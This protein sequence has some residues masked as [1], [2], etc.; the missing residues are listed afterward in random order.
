MKRL[1][2]VS[3]VSI[4][5]LYNAVIPVNAESDFEIYLNDFYQKQEKASQILKGIEREL[6]NGS[7]DKICLKQREAA[8]YGI[9]ATESLIRAFAIN[10]SKTQ[11]ESLI[12]GLDKWKKLRDNC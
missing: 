12:A 8:D 9:Q 1:I 3:L 7:R 11:V 5:Q 10:G 4:F 2:L 6:K